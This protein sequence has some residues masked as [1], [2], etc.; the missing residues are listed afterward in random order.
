MT[1]DIGLL[2]EAPSP[3]GVAPGAKTGQEQKPPVVSGSAEEF[4]HEQ[5]L[6]TYVRD[7]D[8]RSA[9]GASSG[10]STRKQS[11]V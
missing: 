3:D 5:L 9:N 10:I 6:P 4:L 2:S 8:G 11:P 7:V 1:I